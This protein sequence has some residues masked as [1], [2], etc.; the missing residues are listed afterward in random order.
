MI[1]AAAGRSGALNFS[2]VLLS[3]FLS[4]AGPAWGHAVV[5]E[6]SPPDGAALTRPPEQVVLRFNAKIEKSLVRATL[7]TGDGQTIPL[8]MEEE[9]A[10]VAADRLVIP[11][12]PLSPGAYELHFKVLATDGHATLGILRFRI[13]QEP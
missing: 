12:P 5:I 2:L 13:L 4:L 7:K 3:F 1:P 8:S 6:S 11:L 9:E 10:G